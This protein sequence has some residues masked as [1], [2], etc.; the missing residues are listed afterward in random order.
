MT[1]YIKQ[2]DTSPALTG[3]LFNPDGSNPNLAGSTVKFIM[4]PAAGGSAKVDASATVVTASTG[5]VK[6]SWIAADTDTVGSF[7]GEF[8][9]TFSGGA[10]QTYP[11]KGYLKIEVTDDL[12]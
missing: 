7:E 6:Y 12:G 5:N 9:V 11:N 3:Q 8:E 1:I 2:N 10:V 4:R